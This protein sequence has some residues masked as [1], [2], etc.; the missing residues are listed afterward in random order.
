MSS[1]AELDEMCIRD[2]PCVDHFG[3]I[4]HGGEKLAQ[5][6]IIVR[7]Q[8]ALLAQLPLGGFKGDVYKRQ[9]FGSPRGLYLYAKASPFGRGVTAGDGEG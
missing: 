9:A 5:R 4:A 8:A 7:G 1:I 3:V 2:S 6:D